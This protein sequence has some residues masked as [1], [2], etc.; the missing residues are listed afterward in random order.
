MQN[1]IANLKSSLFRRRSRFYFQD[2]RT[3]VTGRLPFFNNNLLRRGTVGLRREKKKN[4]CTFK[5]AVSQSLKNF[6][7]DRVMV[8][9]FY[10]RRLLLELNTQRLMSASHHTD[11]EDYP[12]FRLGWRNVE[13]GTVVCCFS[14]ERKRKRDKTML[15]KMKGDRR[16]PVRPSV[17]LG[18]DLIKN[19]PSAMVQ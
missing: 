1:D 2:R 5:L 11:V 6:G 8:N 17:S 9:G 10:R 3:A 12:A 18:H 4:K 14:R 16:P 15:Y 7:C 13:P 19:L